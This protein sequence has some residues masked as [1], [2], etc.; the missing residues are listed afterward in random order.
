MNKK[1][2][3]YL[4]GVICI[5]ASAAMYFIGKENSNLTELS[6]FWWI[7]LPVAALA[8]IVASKK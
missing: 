7:P 6:Q 5:I 8:L 3:F 1:K 2:L 4:L